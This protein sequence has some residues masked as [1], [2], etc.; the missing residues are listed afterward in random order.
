MGQTTTTPCDTTKVY[1][2]AQGM[3]TFPGGEQKMNK[4]IAQAIKAAGPL[5]A[6]KAKGTVVV[7]CTFDCNGK[8]LKS[9]LEI[10]NDAATPA[11]PEAYQQQA[12]AIVK[13]FPTFL[14]GYLNGR[15]IC[16]FIKIPV[17]FR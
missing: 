12:L 1:S 8:M 7:G 17:Q 3:A 10:S 11:M 4:Y 16:T 15:T 13:S 14:P 6:P 5:N 2:Y 9:M